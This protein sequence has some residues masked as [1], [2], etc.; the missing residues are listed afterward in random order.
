MKPGAHWSTIT[1][2]VILKL[3]DECLKIH[4]VMPLQ[5]KSDKV[6]VMTTLMP[7]LLGH[8]V[9]L[10]NH[11]CGSI[12]TLK[13]DMVVAVEPGIYFQIGKDKS[14]HINTSTW[15]EYE[16]LGGIR[17]EDTIVITSTGYKNLSKVTKEIAG[18][19]KLMK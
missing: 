5:H 2:K 12:T 14:P 19:E 17:I 9:G 18:I 10:D 16:H 7:H 6:K 11:D 4:L 1:H 15:Q 8:H 3:Y 13:K